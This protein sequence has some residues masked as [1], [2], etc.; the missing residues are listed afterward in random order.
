M[1][2]LI[3]GASGFI[4][5]HLA[6]AL[7]KDELCLLV[8]TPSGDPR[9]IVGD[10]TVPESLLGVCRGIDVVFHCAGH[11]HAFAKTSKNEEA[12][13]HHAVNFEGACAMA[14]AAASAGVRRFVLLSS[15]KAA[16]EPG[17]RCVNEAFEGVPETPYG[18][19]KQ[20]AE[21]VVRELGARGGM[22]IV[23]LRPALVYG[24]GGHGNLERMAAMI[25]KGLFPPLPETG[26]KRSLV[27]V[28]D[29]VRA[30]SLVGKESRAAGKTYIVADALAYSGRE[31]YDALR[32]ALGMPPVAV[33]VPRSVLAFGAALG[34]VLNASGLSSFPLNGPVLER[35]TG[36]AWY[37]GAL[38]ENDLGFR[39]QTPLIE[40]LSYLK[41][42]IET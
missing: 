18:R 33:S 17:K 34:D 25:R 10:V 27:H 26:N 36:W 3:T 1:K 39:A 15:V 30:L 14:R 42:G 2:I 6:A 21:N 9:E 40:G 37:D 5:R 23:C 20:D 4:G 11:A 12:E 24:P 22:E 28:D 31:I 32:A 29:L 7:S 19:A 38:I 16:P 41:K 8:R 35:L 13:R